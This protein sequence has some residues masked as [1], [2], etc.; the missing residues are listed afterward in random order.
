MTISAIQGAEQ[1]IAG[2]QLTTAKSVDDSV[3]AA[4][5]ISFQAQKAYYY[6]PA[7]AIDPKTGSVVVEIRNSSTGAVINQYPSEKDLEAYAQ[8]SLK[9]T[10]TSAVPATPVAAAPTQE[11]TVPTAST[12]EETQTTATTTAQTSVI[13]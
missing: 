13:A 9:P 7:L 6:S 3:S 2:I 1:A 12:P 11:K 5:T 8:H 10:D 4:T